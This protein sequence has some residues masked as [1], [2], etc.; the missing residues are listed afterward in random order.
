M[1]RNVCWTDPLM[2]AANVS[3]S[4]RRICARAVKSDVPV[5]Y[6]HVAVIDVAMMR[7]LVSGSVVYSSLGNPEND[8]SVVFSTTRLA[9]PETIAV[10]C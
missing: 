9:S 3:T 2:C 4:A 7:S 8:E 5:W 1:A 10:P 6:T